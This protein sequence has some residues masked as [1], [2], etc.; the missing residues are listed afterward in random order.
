MGMDC[1]LCEVRIQF[2]Y[3]ISTNVARVRRPASP[4]NV[5]DGQRSTGTGFSSSTSVFPYQYHSTNVLYS[6]SSSY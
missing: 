3:T 6:S 4:W 2:L 5:C 1:V